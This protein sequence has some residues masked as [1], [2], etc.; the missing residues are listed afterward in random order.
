[1]DNYS[2]RSNMF[3][4]KNEIRLWLSVRDLFKKRKGMLEAAF[5]V[6]SSRG[7]KGKLGY[8]TIVRMEQKQ[9]A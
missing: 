5:P 7:Q 9:K 2:R 6:E 1:M 3:P 8:E 4:S